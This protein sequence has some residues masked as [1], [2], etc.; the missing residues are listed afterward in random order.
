MSD[1][2]EAWDATERDEYHAEDAHD[3]EP[4]EGPQPGELEARALWSG[5]SCPYCASTAERGCVHRERAKRAA[6]GADGAECATCGE[7]WDLR[8]EHA[9]GDEPSEW[10]R[11]R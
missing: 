3:H 4:H 8:T 2:R 6:I 11:P 5:R 10:P 7:L 1:W 9:C